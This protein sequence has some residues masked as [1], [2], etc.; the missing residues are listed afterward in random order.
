MKNKKPSL[1]IFYLKRTTEFSDKGEAF[2]KSIHWRLI[3]IMLLVLLNYTG[4]GIM[5][6]S[7]HGRSQEWPPRAQ[8]VTTTVRAS[9]AAAPQADGGGVTLVDCTQVHSS[10][11]VD[12]CNL[13]GDSFHLGQELQ[14]AGKVH[15][16][17]KLLSK[18]GASG[19][20]L[21]CTVTPG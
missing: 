5:Q 8:E 7:L 9:G 17:E 4:S 19:N 15:P 3:D 1:S 14:N 12:A 11:C 6:E 21:C 2:L 10:R 20:R 18:A 13:P 16:I